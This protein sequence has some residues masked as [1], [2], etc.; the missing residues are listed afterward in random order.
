MR[1][2]LGYGR[3]SRDE[4]LVFHGR[5]RTAAALFFV[6]MSIF[7]L[8]ATIALHKNQGLA[9]AILVLVLWSGLIFWPTGPYAGPSGVRVVRVLGLGIFGFTRTARVA[10]ADI[11]RFE[12]RGGGRAPYT[13][14]LIRASDQRAISTGVITYPGDQRFPFFERWQATAQ[15]QMDEL[16]ALLQENRKP[17]AP[18][19]R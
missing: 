10:W 6:G 17:K 7:W 5:W 18:P 15:R 3:A 13:A 4:T 11:D 9:A 14:Y 2:N 16:N 1:R 8:V 12:F 19:F